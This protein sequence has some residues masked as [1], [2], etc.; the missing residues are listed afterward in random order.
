M[1]NEKYEGRVQALAEEM[2]ISGERTLLN[3]RSDLIEAAINHYIPAARIAVKY[4]AETYVQGWKDSREGSY[5]VDPL[6][7]HL[8][9]YG[10]IP[11]PESKS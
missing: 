11:E 3:L 8:Q 10:L 5:L 4:M 1:N 2:A 7:L 9:E 6:S